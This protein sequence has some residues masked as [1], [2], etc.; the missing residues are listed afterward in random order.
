MSGPLARM[1]SRVNRFS[2]AAAAAV[3]RADRAANA[4]GSGLRTVAA[5]GTTA[6]FAI[7]A[8]GWNVV[9]TGAKFEKSLM[10]AA[11]RFPGIIKRGSEAYN[12]LRDA[13]LRTGAVTEFTAQQTAEALIALAQA[14]FTAK[15]AIATLPGVVDLATAAEVDLG[16]ASN[17]AADSL[18][19]FGM[20]TTDTKALA[21]NLTDIM[22]TMATVANASTVSLE[23]LYETI[24]AG[25][26]VAK[27]AGI[28]MHSFLAMAGVIAP[29]A[30][31]EKAGMQLKNMF[32]RLAAADGPGK[33][34]LESLGFSAAKMGEELK[35]PIK[36]LRR[37]DAALEKSGNRMLKLKQIVGREPIAGAQLLLRNISLL[38]KMTAQTDNATGASEDM[39][40]A[41]RE[42]LQG[43]MDILKSSVEGLSLSVFHLYNV[44][45]EALIN[46][47]NDWV[48]AV[49]STVD[50]NKGLVKFLGGEFAG[51]IK[52]AIVI[53][54]LW[55][56][57]F[58]ALKTAI[59]VARGIQI[60]WLG[61]L[62]V[63]KGVIWG[64]Q[65]ATWAW[66][67]AQWALNTAMWANPVGLII[68]GIVAAIAVI[69]L[70]IVFWK[71]WTRAVVAAFKAVGKFFVWLW[72][73][74][75]K[76]A[77]FIGRLIG[78]ISNI[79]RVLGFLNRKVK[80]EMDIT[81]TRREAERK[82][83]GEEA[84]TPGAPLSGRERQVAAM[85]AL[86]QT[87]TRSETVTKQDATLT[88][89]NESDRKV[90]LTGK[91]GR[92]PAPAPF[93]AVKS[94]AFR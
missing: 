16:A 69:V 19:A 70:A 12:E 47:A 25:G 71:Q 41:L 65:A 37:F 26:G 42:T 72:G 80:V 33:K 31:G 10:G 39:A 43:S 74:M 46:K 36:F 35:D 52:D 40:R 1:E 2:R 44:D 24:Q 45:L 90:E 13:A 17:I 9:Q 84:A 34:A 59:L 23:D 56:G 81:E 77:D 62:T 27:E 67:A 66:Q 61:I 91:N 54:G 49:K 57:A 79:A 3:G 21:R 60:A 88:V 76:V 29:V 75:T 73:I 51:A 50:K 38:E 14:G 63:T 4:M 6:G 28:G 11:A 48:I 85:R 7:G 32:L 94:G 8:L 55:A 20:M 83:G 15:Q 22:D 93:K 92:G 58:V 30:K 82:K 89:K 5:V 68:A 64:I 18:G 86:A 53:I 78:R 87:S